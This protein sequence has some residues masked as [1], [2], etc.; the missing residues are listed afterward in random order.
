MAFKVDTRGPMI[1]QEET[2]IIAKEQ[3]ETSITAKE[4]EKDPIAA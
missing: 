4:Q 3:E 2:S 1:Y